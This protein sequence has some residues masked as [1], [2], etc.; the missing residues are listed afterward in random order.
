ML[1]FGELI[2]K[3]K[4]KLKISGRA[5]AKAVGVSAPFMH[6][7]EN[8]KRSPF[9][10]GDARLKKLAKV[11]K[12]KVSVLNKAAAVSRGYFELPLRKDSDASYRV[13][14]LLQAKWRKLT[15]AHFDAIEKA[16]RGEP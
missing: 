13:G 14:A 16:V 7:I 8:N 3:Q 6:D 12:L 10:R 2:D 1:N 9:P 5:I 4:K 11:L 15:N